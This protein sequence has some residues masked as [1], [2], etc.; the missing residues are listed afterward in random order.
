MI[1]NPLHIRSNIGGGDDDDIEVGEI[2]PLQGN[3]DFRSKECLDLL[4]EADIIVTN[5]P[6]SL[7]REYV[8]TLMEHNKKFLI[9]GNKNSI[10]YKEI[11]PLIRDNKMWIGYSSPSKFITPEGVT[12][13][14]NGLTRWFTNLDVK[15]RHNFI[16]L[17]EEYTPEKYPKY[18]NYD[19]INV[20]KIKYIPKDYYGVI[21]VPIT[22]LDN[23]NPDQFEIVA[24]RKGEDGK[25]LVFTRERERESSTLLSCPCTT[26]IA[27]MNKN[28]EGKINGKPTYA[29]ILIMRK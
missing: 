20:D 12:K 13:K 24:F 7:Y 14:I 28:A 27:G 5:P 9:I 15:I 10:T 2:T 6:F 26:A 19:A 3:G 21:G 29:R 16:D 18:D 4:D 22:F 1:N 8:A 23:Y 11:F 17:N 25:D